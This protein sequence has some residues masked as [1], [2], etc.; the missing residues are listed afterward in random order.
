MQTFRP[1]L[2]A[3]LIAT[4]A[5]AQS[6]ATNP[7]TA[8]RAPTSQPSPAEIAKLTADALLA[9]RI[10]GYV[11]DGLS[12]VTP[13]PAVWRQASVLLSAAHKLD[14]REPRYPQLLAEVALNAGNTDGAIEAL[15]AFRT[16][17]PGDQDAQI[18]LIDL[19]TGRFQVA[20]K[21]LSYLTSILENPTIPPEVRSYAALSAA[22]L[23]R[24]RSQVKQAKS[25]F[26][27][28]LRLNPL[29]P[30]AL[31]LQFATSE[32]TA[33]AAE[34][35]ALLMRML[36]ANPSQPDRVADLADELA[37]A[38]MIRPSLEWYAFAVRVW[39]RLGQA[40]SHRFVVSYASQFFLADRPEDADALAQ[41]LLS[42]DS[43]DVDAIL[44]RLIAKRTGPADAF[45]SYVNEA[46]AILRGRVVATRRTGEEA[47][48]PV[49]PFKDALPDLAED[50][51]AAEQP[52]NERRKQT[53]IATLSDLAWFQIYFANDTQ[54]TTKTIDILRKLVAE[55]SV[56]LSRL[57][58]WSLLVQ[59]RTQEAMVKLSAVADRD[60]ISAAGVAR[61]QLSDAKTKVDG[62]T[63]ARKVLTDAPAGLLGA[64]VWDVLKDYGVKRGSI[65]AAE[66]ILAQ[67]DKFPRTWL[68][69]VED[70]TAFYS[71]RG[72][73]MRGSYAYGEP[74]FS[75][76]I[77]TNNSEFDITVGPNGVIKPDLWFDGQ[78]RGMVQQ[79]FP[80]ITYDR[81]TQVRV[82]RPKQSIQMFVRVDQGQLAQ[83]LRSN[84]TPALQ[85][86]VSVMTNPTSVA[87]KIDPGAG[88]LKVQFPRV[89]ARNPFPINDE[90]A[91]SKLTASVDT[92]SPSEKFNALELLQGLGGLL[93]QAP[94]EG[95]SV[96][97]EE[98]ERRQSMANQFA[99]VVMRARN[100]PQPSVATW[101]AFLS[102]TATPQ[103]DEF[104][105][106]VRSMLASEEWPTRLMGAVAA[107]SAGPD[108]LDRLKAVAT[109]DEE[110][111]VRQFATAAIEAGQAATTQPTTQP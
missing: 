44:L 76:I 15:K 91:R 24:E 62:N 17:A 86:F 72:E 21:R 40:P 7:P 73:P 110:P 2:V 27:Q 61:I 78:L 89:F 64:V 37:N 48:K 31:T 79:Q 100:D 102:T 65:N 92:G 111:L 52:E 43:A 54:G 4:P 34:R 103:G 63:T 28:A 18:K 53:L 58:G 97:A 68:N 11:R 46:G 105:R 3:M 6:A 29:N 25:L 75:R 106:A 77:I 12:R 94:R 33:T 20:E 22:E 59:G 66:L 32:S 14:P 47:A 108:H 26:D 83:I 80:G 90:S 8:G 70:A 39:N 69:I 23:Y 16:L 30:E 109:D 98:T 42:V 107:S 19:Y 38:G 1:F 10:A 81:I 96:P 45:K 88:G 49:E 104:D 13:T 95:A 82:L 35:V 101:A 99:S 74:M 93:L 55:D 9:Q 85:L 84:P 56:P 57:E 50:I 71:I 51:A 36:M 60:P 67:L 5:L 41:Q 87:G